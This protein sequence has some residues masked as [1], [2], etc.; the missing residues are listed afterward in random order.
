MPSPLPGWLACASLLLVGGL[1]TTASAQFLFDPCCRPCPPP[2]PPPVQQCYRTVPVTEYREVQR[3]VQRPEYYTE[4]EDR[5][6][7]EYRRVCETQA[8]QIPTVSYQTVTECRTVQKDCGRWVTQTECRPK[9]APCDYDNRPDV[10]GAF[11]RAAYSLRMAF[12]P[13]HVSRQCWEPNVVT[14]QIPVTRQVAVRGTRTVNRTVAR[15]VPVTTRRQVAV[16]KMR[17]VCQNVTLRQ[18]VTV[19][20]TVP[21]GNAYAFAS[22]VVDNCQAASSGDRA[23]T[24]SAGLQPTPAGD[25]L[26]EKTAIVPRDSTKAPA[27][28]S[29]KRPKTFTDDTEDQIN[30]SKGKQDQGRAPARKPSRL[31]SFSEDEVAQTPVR[32]SDRPKGVWVAARKPATRPQGEWVARKKKDS[33]GPALEPI[34]LAQA[35]RPRK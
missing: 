11:N 8:V 18:P 30:G 35:S 10:F 9:M 27:E 5:D 3:V 33:A 19:F 22:P 2:C 28:K 16:T 13:D 26:G 20:K 4:Y 7:T 14:Q 17:M 15:I 25:D 24:A 29:D 6:V 34:I 31:Q 12:T 32:E 1:S 21:V 23:G